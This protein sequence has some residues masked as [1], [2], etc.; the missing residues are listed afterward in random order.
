[1][2]WLAFLQNYSDYTIQYYS[3]VT[4]QTEELSEHLYHLTENQNVNEA[5]YRNIDIG[6]A[7]G[8]FRDTWLF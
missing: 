4:F 5:S 2:V 3:K 6:V 7:S 1:M 8:V